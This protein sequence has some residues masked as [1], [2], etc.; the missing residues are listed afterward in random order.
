[1]TQR[2]LVEPCQTQDLPKFNVALDAP[3]GLPPK[4]ETIVSKPTRQKSCPLSLFNQGALFREDMP[5]N[6]RGTHR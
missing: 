6:R 1:M 4:G 5:H 3:T 2:I